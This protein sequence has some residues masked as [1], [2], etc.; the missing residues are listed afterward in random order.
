M[1]DSLTVTPG[2]YR[3]YKGGLYDVI[4]V[5]RHSETDEKLVVYRP[6]YGEKALWVRPMDMF[7]E[8][9]TVHGEQVPRFNRLTEST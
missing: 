5:A 4:G 1:T 7:I 2:T 8:T 6:R 9:V 3:H